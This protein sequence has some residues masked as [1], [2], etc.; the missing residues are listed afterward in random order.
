MEGAYVITNE[1]TSNSWGNPR[2]YTIH[3]GPLVHLTNLDSKRTEK[4]VN[5]AKHHL[6]VSRRKEEEPSSSSM[7][8]INLPGAPP[9]DFYRVNTM[10]KYSTASKAETVQ[11]FDN[12]TIT[13]EDLVVW[14]NLGTHH[15]PRAE[16]T[17]P[18]LF[19]SR[20]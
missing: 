12:E 19:L 11:F 18:T 1:N 20:D 10:R 17:P 15:I 2:G 8:N 13:Q 14:V 4:N 6:A 5:W 9:V 7:W 3:P 16:G